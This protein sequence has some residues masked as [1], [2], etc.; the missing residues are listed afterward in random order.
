VIRFFQEARMI[1]PDKIRRESRQRARNE[2]ESSI[3]RQIEMMRWAAEE[4]KEREARKKE[5]R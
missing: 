4:R 5:E 3:R 1:D 2:M